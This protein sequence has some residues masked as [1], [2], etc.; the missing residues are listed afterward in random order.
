MLWDPTNAEY[1]NINTSSRIWQPM[2]FLIVLILHF[3]KQP[4][5]ADDN[6]QLQIL[7]FSPKKLVADIL[8]S[9]LIFF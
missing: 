8:Y 3:P 6:L 7:C 1:S 4:E 9:S 2:L 5:I